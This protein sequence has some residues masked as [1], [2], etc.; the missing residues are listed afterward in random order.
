[1]SKKTRTKLKK[2]FSNGRM[3]SE[4]DF[5]DLI[6]STINPLDDGFNLTQEEGIQIAPTD[7]GKFARIY[8]EKGDK[9]NAK[10]SLEAGENN[11]Y[12]LLKNRLSAE[13]DANNTIKKEKDTP[14]VLS[15]S[16]REG[17]L[18]VNKSTPEFD[19]D[20]NGVLASKARIGTFK[21]GEVVADGQW[22][23]ILTGLEGCHMLEITAG[24]AG[25][26]KQGR[27]ALVHAIAMNCYNPNDFLSWFRKRIKH[28][29]A[30]YFSRWD[31][32]KMR[33]AKDGYN[34]YKLQIKTVRNYKTNNRNYRIKFHITQL[35]V[36]NTMRSSFDDGED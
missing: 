32:I 29:H 13:D 20:V 16:S 24:I 31:K 6:D 19:L 22:K 9:Q 3:P 17:K 34:R 7:L 8:S 26:E 35:W 18:A 36:E 28:Q 21:S 1:M 27:Y 23:D 14:P 2:L 4:V 12:L 30:W 15:I 5:A 11:D 25:G 33:W 10:W